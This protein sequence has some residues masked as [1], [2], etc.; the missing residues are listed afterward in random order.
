MA[1]TRLLQYADVDDAW[2][3]VLRPWLVACEKNAWTLKSPVA[4]VLP[5]AATVAY[6]KG[7][8][9]A[10][11]M[12][13]MGVSFLTPGQLRSALL[14]SNDTA[15]ALAIR[16]ELHLIA[17]TAAAKLPINPIA[18]SIVAHPDEFV[19]ACDALDGAGWRVDGFPHRD[20]K[21]L[22]AHYF[23]MLDSTGLRSVF[24]VDRDLL[25]PASRPSPCFSE[26]L[27]FGFSAK[28]W[29]QYSL[30]MACQHH[31]SNVLA[32]LPEQG[33]TVAEEMWSNQWE[34]AFGAAENVNKSDDPRVLPYQEPALA[35]DRFEPL[36]NAA[37]DL[38]NFWMGG[39]L[40]EEAQAIIDQA[41]HYLNDDSCERLGIVFSSRVTPIAREVASRLVE[42]NIPH[43]DIPGHNPGQPTEQWLFESWCD[44]QSAQRLEGVLELLRNLHLE[45]TVSQE[46]RDALT[47]DL[48]RSFRE[49][50][51]DDLKVLLAF[52]KGGRRADG[53]DV[54]FQE[55]CL[56][57]ERDLFAAF[58]E[59]TVPILQKI[60]WPQRQDTLLERAKRLGDVLLEPIQRD[61]FLVWLRAVVNVP[62]RTRPDLGREPFARV[63]LITLDEAVGQTW[64]HVILAG[65]NKGAWPPEESSSAFLEETQMSWL[66]RKASVQGGQGEGHLVLAEGKGYLV[67]SNERRRRF[68][69]DFLHLIGN[70]K[71]HVSLT[72]CMR[73]PED[74]SR[75]WAP[76]DLWMRIFYVARDALFSLK[77]A[78]KLSEK[79]KAFLQA[80]IVDRDKT[81]QEF[82][83]VKQAYVTRRDAEAP[84]DEYSFSFNQA[85]EGG[86]QLSCK[87]WE[88]AIKRPANAWYEHVLKVSKADSP[89]KDE[90]RMLTIGTWL[91]DW[92]NP[93]PKEKD[94]TLLPELSDWLSQ[95]DRFSNAERF[96]VRE[97][98]VKADRELPDWWTVDWAWARKLVRSFALEIK[99]QPG[100]LWGVGEYSLREHQIAT[101]PGVLRLPA[102]G[103]IDLVLSQGEVSLDALEKSVPSLW[104]LDFKTGGDEILSEKGL[105][106]GSGIQMALYALALYGA[107]AR[108]IDVSVVRPNE[109]LKVQLTLDEILDSKE[110]WQTV[111]KIH[112]TG[113][114]GDRGA[115]RSEF[116]F[117]GDY[118]W[119]TLPVAPEILDAKW[120]HTL[121]LWEEG[122]DSSNSDQ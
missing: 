115:V 28:H 97:A 59:Q 47:R 53:F 101:V 20:A 118:P 98:Y 32:C 90:V 68:E 2:D 70:V 92:V 41:V 64:S 38:F 103:R 51:T 96:A 24:Q 87:A 12:S 78:E 44:F 66:N 91:H 108:A 102:R 95:V 6:V 72:A 100:P 89:A 107:G 69:Q 17:R 114:F 85:P 10:E 50:M 1:S 23:S 22:A 52:V 9:L 60:G 39:D 25:Q 93:T 110:L 55:W 35:A 5:N 26:L 80:S 61:A 19:K 113:C 18:Q 29:E 76:S 43:H 111:S 36:K 16:E 58:F 74:K 45:G 106:N 109:S 82:A 88:T 77:E 49:C 105:A 11:E 3:V 37:P 15:P 34:E 30:L 67:S 57:P 27:I 86:V 14:R 31:A 46:D 75:E 116:S 94:V 13:A 73:A 122:S 48:M 8:L 54:F 71:E 79:T 21:M 81:I 40:M 62:G 56:L 63:Q 33:A 99:N 4:M 112:E 120:Q 119:A 104:I 7:R 117:T 83:S 42:L 84:F 121:N 65:M